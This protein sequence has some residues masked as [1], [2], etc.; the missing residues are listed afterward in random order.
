M[1]NPELAGAI[2]APA[3]WRVTLAWNFGDDNWL[4]KTVP[5][6]AFTLEG[7]AV[8]PDLVDSLSKRQISRLIA[9]DNGL[10]WCTDGYTQ[11]Q[12]NTKAREMWTENLTRKQAR[13]AR[14]AETQGAK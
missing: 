10:I 11:D 8:V 13:E 12:A 9:A 5:V 14:Q 6:A 1:Y 7:K 4:Y 2:P 3:G